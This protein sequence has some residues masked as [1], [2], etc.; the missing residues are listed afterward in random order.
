MT[1][2]VFKLLEENL[3]RQKL[4]QKPK[5]IQYNNNK[6]FYCFGSNRFGFFK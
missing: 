6:K 5:K 1:F 3:E 4:M 2:L